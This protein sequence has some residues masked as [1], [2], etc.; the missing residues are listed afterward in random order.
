[1]LTKSTTLE[2]KLRKLREQREESSEEEFSDTESSRVEE[3][4]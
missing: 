4:M 3:D 1:M 2:D